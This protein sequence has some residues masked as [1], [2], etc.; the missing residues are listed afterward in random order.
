MEPQFKNCLLLF[1]LGCCLHT[2]FAAV[3]INELNSNVPGQDTKEYIE[4]YNSGTVSVSLDD[5]VIV[6]FDGTTNAAYYVLSLQGGSIASDGYFVIGSSNVV[7]NPDVDFGTGVNIVQNGDDAVALYRGPIAEFTV[8]MSVTATSL[9]DAVVYYRREITD[10]GLVDVLT[11]NQVPLR[12]FG[13][14][15]RGEDESLSRCS[16][17]DPLK[18][19]QFHLT[20]LTPGAQN[21]CTMLATDAPVLIPPVTFPG[22]V[23]LPTFSPGMSEIIPHIVINEIGVDRGSG[24]FIE[25]FDGGYGDVSLDGIII[26]LYRSRT[27]ASYGNAISLSGFRTDSDGYFLLGHSSLQP[28]A[29]LRRTLRTNRLNAIALYFESADNMPSLTAVTGRNLIDAVVYSDSERDRSSALIDVLYAGATPLVT[30]EDQTNSSFVRCRSWQS[31]DTS[32]FTIGTQT[33]GEDNICN[34]YLPVFFINEINVAVDAVITDQFIEIFDG[35]IGFQSLDGVVV[36]LY[37]GR[38]SLSYNAIDLASYS[39]NDKGFCVIGWN[40]GTNV[41]VVV[42]FDAAVGF[43]QPGPD[44]VALHF[45]PPQRFAKGKA[46]TDY[47]LIDA[48]V[49]GDNPALPL[50]HTLLPNQQVLNELGGSISAD[51]SISRC[52]CCQSLNTTAFGLG[53]PS[54]GNINVNCIQNN[55]T[56]I[57]T[58][59][60]YVNLIRL[61]EIRISRQDA[62]NGDFVEIYDGGFGGVNLDGMVLVLYS[63]QGESSYKTIDLNGMST[64]SSGFV[65]IGPRSVQSSGILVD[66]DHWFQGEAGAVAIH[67]GSS[68]DFPAGTQASTTNLMDAVVYGDSNLLLVEL[69]TPGQDRLIYSIS[70]GETSILRCFSREAFEVLA[71]SIGGVSPGL[72]NG[73]CP[74]PPIT[75]NEVNVEDRSLT[76]GEYVEL[77]SN[78]IPRFPLNDILMIFWRGSTSLSYRSIVLNGKRTDKNGLFLIGY[79][80][81]SSPRPDLT[82]FVA[83]NSGIR[84]G[85]NA[86][87]IHKGLNKYN[88]PKRTP[89]T[90][91]SLIDAIVHGRGTSQIAQ[92]LIDFFKPNTL[93]INEVDSWSDRDES[94]NRCQNTENNTVYQLAHITPK[95][96]NHCPSRADA[97]LIINEINLIPSEQFIELWDLGAG[98]TTLDDFVVVLFGEDDTS[99]WRIPLTGF[100]TDSMGYFIMGVNS[101][102]PRAQFVF[103]DGFMRYAVG[104]VAVYRASLVDSIIEGQSASSQGLLDAIVYSN[105]D[106]PSSELT[107]VLTPTFPAVDSRLLQTSGFSLS[108]CLSVKRR[109]PRSFVPQPQSPKDFNTCPVYS[110]DVII[111][112]INVQHPGQSAEEEFIELYDGGVGFTRLRFLSLV[113]FNGNY[114]DRSYLTVDLHGKHTDRSGYLVIASRHFSGV[115][116]VAITTSR[117]GFLQ[118]G[119][120]AVA[121]YRAPVG[122]FPHGTVASSRSLVDAII[123]S[124][125]DKEHIS[126]V[127]KIMPGGY[128]VVEDSNHATG[129]ETISRCK[130][131]QR[132]SPDVYSMGLPTPGQVNNCTQ[133]SGVSKTGVLINEVNVAASNGG[134]EFIE[135]SSLAR[136]FISL[137]GFVLVFYNGD[138][139]DRSYLELDLTGYM[140]NQN[141]F[142]VVGTSS[143]SPTPHILLPD[144]FLQHGP[145][146]IALYYTTARLF[147]RG[148]IATSMDLVDVLIYGQDMGDNTLLQKLAPYQTPA[149]EDP[150]YSEED[151]S[152]SRC[153]SN[154]MVSLSAFTVSQPTPGRANLCSMTPVVIN[155]VKLDGDQVGLIELYDGGR[156]STP[157]DSLSIVLYDYGED[158]P[159]AYS[160]QSLAGHSTNMN[161]YFVYGKP[162]TEWQVDLEI[163]P[164]IANF[165]H[166]TGSNAVVL[167]KDKG[168]ASSM[169]DDEL[170]DAMVY[171]YRDPPSTQLIDALLPGQS[172]IQINSEFSQGDMS[173]S[174]CKCCQKLHGSAFALTAPTPQGDNLCQTGTTVATPTAII[175]NEVRPGT[176][177]SN[178]KEFVELRGPPGTRL[179]AYTLVLA[180][181]SN[182]GPVYYNAFSLES[183]FISSEGKFVIGTSNVI[184]PPNAL[185]PVSGDSVIRPGEGAVAVYQMPYS[186][187]IMGSRVTSEDLVDAVVFTND[188]SQSTRKLSSVLTPGFQGFFTGNLSA[189]ADITN[190]SI[191]R[192]TCC[193]ITDPSVFTLST[194]TPGHTNKCPIRKFRQ[195]VQLH[196]LDAAYDVWKA[197]PQFGTDVKKRIAEG[198]NAEC[199]CGFREFYLKDSKLLN[200]SVYYEVEMFALSESQS[201]LLF[202]SYVSFVKKTK[203][204]QVLGTEFH[205]SSECFSN[206]IHGK[207]TQQTGAAGTKPVVAVA[208]VIVVVVT[209]A[210]VSLVLYIVIH[211]RHGILSLIKNG[212]KANGM[213]GEFRVT[214]KCTINDLDVLGDTSFTNGAGS[215]GNPVYCLEP[216]PVPKPQPVVIEC[217]SETTDADVTGESSTQANGGTEEK[218]DSV[219][220]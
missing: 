122:A 163:S 155:E 94:I 220:S 16:G 113:L 3:L 130:G 17:T 118:D 204:I 139:Q 162:S 175:I 97:E 186:A 84:I 185:F 147:P 124:T 111:N 69:L 149:V 158:G 136:G 181:S 12:E 129:D 154:H 28:D 65:V 15:F 216:P 200:G 106:N 1:I 13:G 146:A 105:L 87:S 218:A 58:F 151:E 103:A 192:C 203:T 117:D 98:F 95:A 198:V 78:G 91:E 19:S 53:T 214:H 121:L 120:D 128:V 104:A 85:P 82:P 26:V 29:E 137:N 189:I 114:E 165:P 207:S 199:Q 159:T 180:A 166:N 36:V 174:R 164:S 2:V 202:D 197:N 115:S 196:I 109:A 134:G 20:V 125:E 81:L 6:L 100:T 102:F 21:N 206:C 211:R 108:R 194:P 92:H 188:S 219:Q 144:N 64:D 112:E 37:N 177:G 57:E 107:N 80:G 77:S 153:L 30:P 157:L 8:G 74:L 169:D 217:S 76:I 156:G 14:H 140:T 89:L 123:Y 90:N 68:G 152:L 38:N 215:F 195:T 45:G 86:I 18:L 171:G 63:S 99:V 133:Q 42:E 179:D 193:D 4:L 145:D 43:L 182:K 173:I 201:Q 56:H 209:I 22:I 161:G 54:P 33:P 48:V 213:E 35:G 178:S 160:V 61:N 142:F 73:A 101:V 168:T 79:Q 148:T 75:I 46:V 62:P 66:E 183:R 60:H 190:P 5:Y 50:L 170:V 110:N 27:E 25:L 72:P 135:L 52:S 93:Q 7:P 116:N 24:Q 83:P 172:Q 32:A 141:G 210:V 176:Q 41:D 191:S 59:T 71:Y 49:Y 127:E 47:N 184:P 131:D 34:Q 132:L 126:L 10:S 55:K 205:I 88:F 9:V 40:N 150:E 11:P 212:G 143:V 31:L 44:A 96:P 119:P 187:T 51:Q 23:D 39:T 67:K 138:N 70:T 167:Y 208:I